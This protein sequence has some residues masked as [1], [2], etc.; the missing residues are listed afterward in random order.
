M[1]QC[2]GRAEAM[3]RRERGEFHPNIHRCKSKKLRD[4]PIFSFP[5]IE[6][7]LLEGMSPKLQT[8]RFA[9]SPV[10]LSS[11]RWRSA[12][13]AKQ[14]LPIFTDYHLHY[15]ALQ[16]LVNF[17][18]IPFSINCASQAKLVWLSDNPTRA[19]LENGLSLDAKSRDQLASWSRHLMRCLQVVTPIDQNIPNLWI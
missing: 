3:Q 15:F 17:N 5:R 2:S 8:S 1:G 19:Q 9:T 11:R 6:R 16:S 13:Y 10:I 7:C 14:Y 4:I 12:P 18:I